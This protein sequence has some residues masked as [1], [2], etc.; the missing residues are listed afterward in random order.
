MNGFDTPIR[1]IVIKVGSSVLTDARG[2][3]LPARIE[4]LAKGAAACERTGHVPVI[5]SS[6]AIACGMARLGLPRRPKALAQLQACAAIGQ[7]ELMHVYNTIFGRRGLVTAQVLLTQDDLADRARYRNAKQTLLTL[8][9][10]RVVPIINENDTLA[11]EEITFGDNDRHA[12]FVACAIDANLLVILSDVDGLLEHGTVIQR[13]EALSRA[14]RLVAPAGARQT[15][16]GGMA[17]ELEAAR[18]ITARGIPMVIANGT[19]PSALA[20]VLSGK[21]IGTFFVP[22]RPGV[23]PSP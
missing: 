11:V 14:Y 1:R 23:P 13:V 15:T 3:L 19:S 10:R 9:H 5:V 4:Q 18:M 2:R 8:L 20:G 22:R 16:K 21:S 7:S 12:A 6:G 17:S